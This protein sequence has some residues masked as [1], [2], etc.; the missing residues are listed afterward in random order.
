ML[1]LLIFAG[2]LG[3]DAVSLLDAEGYFKQRNIAISV[4]QMV[5]LAT[6]DPTSGKAQVRQLLALRWLAD[7]A[8]AVKKDDS[9]ANL[10]QQL[11]AVA[12]GQKAQDLQ[13]F[14]AE[15]ARHTV[16]ALGGKLRQPEPPNSANLRQAALGWFP[17][18][19]TFAAAMDLRSGAA[20]N[21]D[22]QKR[23]RDLL[24]KMIPPPIKEQIYSTI[25]NLGN[26]RVER[27]A[28][29]FV[30]GNG[31]N[32]SKIFMRVIGK[33][34]H[35]R[36]VAMLKETDPTL[37]VKELQSFRGRSI[38]LIDPNSHELLLALI[39]D[40]DLLVAG[41]PRPAI[42]K[43]H[44]QVI[45][46]ALDVRRGKSD[47]V[48]TGPLAK[49]LEKVSAQAVALAVGALPQ[50][51]RR[52]M[53]GPGSPLPVL[54]TT[55]VTELTAGKKGGYEFHLHGQLDNA[56][57]AKAFAQGVENLK[58]MALA[59]LQNPPLPINFPNA[60][61]LL[62][63]A[64]KALESLK[65]EVKESTAQGQMK[66]S[67]SLVNDYQQFGMGMVGMAF[68]MQGGQAAPPVP[69]VPAEKEEAPK[70]KKAPAKDRKES[71]KD[72]SRLYGPRP[73]LRSPASWEQP[74]ERLTFAPEVVPCRHEQ[75]TRQAISA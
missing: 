10:L 32:Q 6:Q 38:T 13:G 75:R 3:N 7:H 23:I 27:I 9:F 21:S 25:E 54:P 47:S 70:D 48:L 5:E 52:E 17:K 62:K 40:N 56:E 55:L 12:E 61:N 49:H 18:S 50:E 74:A 65:V 66:I 44:E 41:L 15:Y 43:E 30:E 42:N 67:Q 19:A 46:E 68:E 64:R 14:A 45:Q 39:G 72:E 31:N 24:T 69:P 58:Q 63:E 33:G 53:T 20:L 11:Q 34:N 22:T 57:D 26:V 1:M 4:S 60:A 73:D 29:A 71:K 59:Q 37:K 35:K 51:M 36:L 16:T 8:G 28:F 2:D